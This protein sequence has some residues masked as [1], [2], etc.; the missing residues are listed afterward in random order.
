MNKIKEKVDNAL[1]TNF[2][3]VEYIKECSKEQQPILSND[4]RKHQNILDVPV[5]RNTFTESSSVIL[6]INDSYKN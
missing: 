6:E 5:K 4:I 1:D 3:L 2:H